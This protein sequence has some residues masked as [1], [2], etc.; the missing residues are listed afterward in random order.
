MTKQKSSWKNILIESVIAFSTA[1]LVILVTHEDLF[2][3]KP[4]RELELKFLDSRFLERGEI[5]IKDSAQVIIVEINQDTYDGLPDEHRGWPWPRFLYS[6]LINNLNAAG[7]KAIGIDILMSNPDQYN[8]L[9][10]SLLMQAIRRTGNVVV[11]AKIDIE[12]EAIAQQMEQYSISSSDKGG[13]LIVKQKEN[14]GNIFYDADKSI[15]IVQIAS[16]ADGVHRRYRPYSYSMVNNQYI[17]SFGFA[18][19]NKYFGLPPD[20]KAES[21][22]DHFLLAGMKIPKFDPG[23]MLINFYGKSRSFPYYSFLDIVDDKYFQTQAE[24][25]YETDLNS[26][27]DPDFGYLNSG[28]FKDKIVLVGS[29]MP[30][31]KDILPVSMAA[32]KREGDNTLY[33]VE[34]HA[35]AIQNIIRGDFIEK[36]S[37]TSEIITIFI[38]TVFIF[39]I[40]SFV[41]KVKVKHGIIIEFANL[42]ITVVSVIIIYKLSFYMFIE[43]NFV[44]AIVSPVMAVVLGYFSSTAYHFIKERRQ[45]VVIRGMFSQYVSSALVNELI[46]NPDKLRL[47][48]EKKNLSILFSD[49]AGFTTFSEGKEPEVLVSF[50]NEFLHEMTDLVLSNNGTL[51]KYLGDA[52]MAFWGAPIPLD[53]H[54]FLACKTALEMENRLN[55]LR[56][57]WVAKGEKPLSIRIGINSG[58]VVVGNIGGLERFDYT[59]MGDVVNLASRLEGANKAYKTCIMI[60]E[61]TYEDVKDQVIVRELDRIQVKGKTISTKVF[62][63]L[64]MV[65]DEKAQRKY[66]S[67]ELYYEG[68]SEYKNR[69]FVEASKLFINALEKNENDYPSQVYLDRCEFYIKAPPPADWDGV[70]IM[71]TK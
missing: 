17:P 39:M 66:D 3:I 71:K 8:P 12:R 57:E 14:Y 49:I 30:E 52:I 61:N 56:D 4:L 46:A 21:E 15:G 63:L 6:K 28:V 34:V 50:M 70:F 35:T 43:H 11:A 19:L 60:G 2:P 55:E 65:G 41:K 31:D 24:R 51:D 36:Q 32:G 5:D 54:A 26:W 37:S 22:G 25:E 42:L 33:G 58:D 27:D 23:S 7:V 20:A 48:G 68:L 10:D 9:N 44:L 38:L 13:G 1:I 16:D 40:S 69:N 45:N 67:F 64:G 53:N 47:G 62:E 59:V 29:S 18:I